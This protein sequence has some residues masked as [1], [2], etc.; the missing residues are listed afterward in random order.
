MVSCS[1]ENKI[2]ESEVLPTR[3]RFQEALPTFNAVI[4]FN[5]LDPFGSNLHFKAYVPLA[6][7]SFVGL[8]LLFPEYLVHYSIDSASFSCPWAL[9]PLLSRGRLHTSLHSHLLWF[10]YFQ[11]PLL[12]SLSCRSYPGGWC[13]LASFHLSIW[14]VEAFLNESVQFQRSIAKGKLIICKLL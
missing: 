11:N 12:A 4:S 9:G 1:L 14:V 6:I 2:E 10:Y 13:K 5:G 7:Q 8:T 3:I